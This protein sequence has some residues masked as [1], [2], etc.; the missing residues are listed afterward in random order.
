MFFQIACNPSETAETPI[1]TTETN[2]SDGTAEM[3]KLLNESAEKINPMVIPF[4]FNRTRADQFRTAVEKETV[5]ENQLIGQI[6]YSDE[7]LKAGM[8]EDAVMVLENLLN[9][10]NSFGYHNK[11]IFDKINKMLA[12]SYIRLGEQNNCINRYNADKRRRNL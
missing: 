12:L 1:E 11:T 3:I 9:Q 10:L 4:Y 5:P 8:N 2:A 6:S 7:L